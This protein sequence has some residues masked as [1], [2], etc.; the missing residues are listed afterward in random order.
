[1]Q[2]KIGYQGQ[3]FSNNHRA[4]LQLAKKQGFDD[5]ILLPLTTSKNVV[6]AL[7]RKEID[8][9]VLALKNSI[10]GVVKESYEA[11]K[12]E[13]LELVNV[14][15][16]HVSHCVF[17]KGDKL[18]NTDIKKI[19]SH[20]QA[21]K[22]CSQTLARLF[23]N[24]ELTAV[25]DT[26]L[27]AKYVHEGVYDEHTAAI[28]SKEAGLH[29]GLRLIKEDVQDL[30]ENYTE[31][32]LYQLGTAGGQSRSFTRT[33]LYYLLGKKVL[34]P[35]LQVAIVLLI[36][37]AFN[38]KQW[39]KLS[40][41][42]TASYIASVLAALFFF[43]TSKT[44]RN[45]LHFYSIK[46]YWKYTAV[47]DENELDT[48]HR[49]HVPRLVYIE[50]RDNELHVTGW[51]AD[52]QTVFFQSTQALMSTLGERNGKFVYWYET[53]DHN[54]TGARASGIVTLKWTLPHP[55]DKIT[56]MHGKYIGDTTKDIG[57]CTFVRISKNE[58]DR[59]KELDFL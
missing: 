33:I 59:I 36:V 3:E 23:P 28:C 14:H 7:K 48:F 26:S 8:Y 34:E 47:S 6:N 39:F 21:L 49:Y 40:N 11:I 45:W 50:T 52:N 4:A 10:A 17:L 57:S 55:A 54:A 35:V 18:A 20:E 44:F 16:L 9:G 51:I 30:H 13:S 1:M 58:F 29:F 38:A 46:G 27:A 22:Q 24:A 56:S 31:M 12:N 5:F 32:R 42:E 2:K 15:P 41:Y 43:L 37:I 53:V 25:A 19:I